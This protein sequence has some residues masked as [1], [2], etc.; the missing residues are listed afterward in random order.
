MNGFNYI[1]PISDKYSVL[2]VFKIYKAEVENQ[3]E[4][5]IVVVRSDCEE[6]YYERYDEGG[7]LKGPFESYYKIAELQLSI[8]CL[9]CYRRMLWMKGGTEPL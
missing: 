9:E 3:L 1:I 7:Q 4:K 8:Q 2:D 6:E 5:K